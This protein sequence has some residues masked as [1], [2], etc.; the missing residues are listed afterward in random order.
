VN[1]L[2]RAEYRESCPESEAKFRILRYLATLLGDK[3]T[4][5]PPA[6]EDAVHGEPCPRCGHVNHRCDR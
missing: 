5:R 6:P 4:R 2:S 3:A 1:E